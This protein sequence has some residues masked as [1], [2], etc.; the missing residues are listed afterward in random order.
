MIKRRAV[1]KTIALGPFVVPL[2][3]HAQLPAKLSR[4]GLMA[5]APNVASAIR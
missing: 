4:I 1:I 3:A 2:A 5:S